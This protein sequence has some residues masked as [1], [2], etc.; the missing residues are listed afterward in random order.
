MSQIPDRVG[1]L[2]RTNRVASLYAIVSKLT[3]AKGE[4]VNTT[5]VYDRR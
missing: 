3:N 1:T 5:L 2:T 4:V